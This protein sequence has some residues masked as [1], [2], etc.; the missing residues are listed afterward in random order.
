MKKNELEQLEKQMQSLV[1]K[2][3]D[4]I[5]EIDHL[6]VHSPKFEQASTECDTLETEYENLS[7]KYELRW[8]KIYPCSLHIWYILEL[9]GNV[10][11]GLGIRQCLRCKQI[12]RWNTST[13]ALYDEI[14]EEQMIYI[15]QNIIYQKNPVVSY[16]LIRQEYLELESEGYTFEEIR[17]ILYSKYTKENEDLA[18]NLKMKYMPK[19]GE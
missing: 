17:E 2:I 14:E 7:S 19:H 15:Y 13:F 1:K 6:D 9:S 12:N 3:M 11:N 4:K 8:Q 16:E 10:D 18:R 5:D